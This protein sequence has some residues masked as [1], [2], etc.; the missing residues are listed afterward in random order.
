[1]LSTAPRRVAA[2]AAALLLAAHVFDAPEPFS[3]ADVQPLAASPLAPTLHHLVVATKHK[4]GLDLL[5]LSARRLGYATRVLGAADARPIGH[6]TTPLCLFDCPPAFGLKMTLV[7]EAVAALPPRDWVLFTDAY[8]VVFA[9]PAADLVRALEAWEAR[10]PP[11]AALVFGAE[12]LAWPDA[13]LPG[14]AARSAAR[15]AAGGAAADAYPFLNSGVYAGRAAAVL[16]AVAGGYDIRTNDQRFFTEMLVGSAAAP[17][18]PAAA[19]VALDDAQALFANFAGTAAGA[20]WRIEPR[21]GGDAGGGGGGAAPAW[22]PARVL[23]PAPGGG[24]AAHEPFVLHFNSFGKRHL[25]AVAAATHGAA[26][27]ALGDVAQHDGDEVRELFLQPAKAVLL[28]PLPRAARA[29][30]VAARAGDAAAAAMVVAL[31]A[32][33]ARGAAGCVRRRAAARAAGG[34]RS[35]A[36]EETKSS[37]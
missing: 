6:H 29:A 17:R 13:G 34:A 5:L 32:A 1:M 24:G 8:D 22:S 21:G 16:A 4:P 37:V 20:D 15:V 14:Y 9:R 27:A 23:F 35:R 30:L 10:A 12:K 18:A 26:G 7:K 19:R 33:A 3:R 11:G 2:L 28:A 31:V 25:L 36:V